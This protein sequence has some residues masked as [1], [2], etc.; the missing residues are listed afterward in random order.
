MF[1]QKQT[2]TKHPA[3]I[4]IILMS[5]FFAPI[6]LAWILFETNNTLGEGKTNHGQ[7]IIPSFSIALL[8]L[9]NENGQILDNR[10]FLQMPG[11]TSTNGKWMMLLFITKKCN[12][13][14]QQGLYNMRQ[15]RLATGK[16]MNRIERAILIYKKR[17]NIRLKNLIKR[18]YAGT[19]LFFANKQQLTFIIQKH[20]K[21]NYALQNGTL[22]L[23]DPLGNVMMSYKP[24]IKANA[25][26]QDLTRLL[27]VS[28][29][30]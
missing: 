29:I 26:F 11:T 6:L 18:E 15:I 19:Q 20:V 13:L 24:G 21:T 14:C 12:Q 4:I 7:L 16:D 1:Q 28:Q 30:G 2:K 3:V 8:T 23:V 10:K 17:Q 9:Y 25:I 5:L 22:Y 27:K